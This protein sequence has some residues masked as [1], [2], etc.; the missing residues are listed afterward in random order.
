MAWGLES[1]ARS[2]WR[3]W[4]RSCPGRRGQLSRSKSWGEPDMCM[5]LPRMRRLWL[6]RGP[7]SPAA[8]VSESQHVLRRG[9]SRREEPSSF[10]AAPGGLLPRWPSRA[11]GSPGLSISPSLSSADVDLFTSRIGSSATRHVIAAES[12]A[13]G[14]DRLS[15]GGPGDEDVGLLAGRGQT[16]MFLS[17]KYREGVALRD[18]RVWRL[19]PKGGKVLLA[20][21]RDVRALAVDEERVP[22]FH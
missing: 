16:L 20:R 6:L 10:T 1:H 15:K 17:W 3:L 14:L 8:R 12:S 13:D 21:V 5:S 11:I 7:V 4:L 19:G 22:T 9:T 18:E 2:Q